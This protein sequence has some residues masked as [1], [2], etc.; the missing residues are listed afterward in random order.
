MCDDT[1]IGRPSSRNVSS[2]SSSDDSSSS[3]SSSTSSEIGE[4]KEKIGELKEEVNDLRSK[5]DQCNQAAERLEEAR[6]ELEA[7]IKELERA[8]EAA[9]KEL[10]E[11]IEDI[12]H[13]DATYAARLRLHLED[14]QGFINHLRE[15]RESFNDAGSFTSGNIN[16]VYGTSAPPRSLTSTPPNAQPL[17]A[18]MRSGGSTGLSMTSS[19]TGGL[20]GIFSS[21]V[22]NPPPKQRTGLPWVDIGLFGFGLLADH[23]IFGNQKC[24]GGT[25]SIGDVVVGGGTSL[26]N[27]L[28]KEVGVGGIP[29]LDFNRPFAGGIPIQPPKGVEITHL[30]GIP[31]DILIGDPL[32]KSVMVNQIYGVDVDVLIGGVRV[33]GN[34]DLNDV[35]VNNLPD[36]LPDGWRHTD[37]NGRIHIR[38]EEGKIRI[39]VDPPDNVG[40]PYRHKHYYDKDYKPLDVNGNSVPQNSPDAHIPLQ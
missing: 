12:R 38:D 9:I 39:R 5:A 3:S 22:K 36:S 21:F 8:I 31:I 7:A 34:V 37:N 20:G 32:V 6:K 10:E 24:G 19:S 35:D 27:S 26:P 2:S 40:T 29:A 11:Y 13:T 4:L 28:I 16:L 18:P 25:V 14:F 23:I 30:H 1:P 15:I 33:S 17:S